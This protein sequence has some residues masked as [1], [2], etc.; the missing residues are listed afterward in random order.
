MLALGF[1]MR[2]NKKHR[3]LHGYIAPKRPQPGRNMANMALTYDIGG[4]R[5]NMAQNCCRTFCMALKVTSA[6]KP[7]VLQRFLA[8]SGPDM[9]PT[10]PQMA[11]DGLNKFILAQHRLNMAS[12]WP[13]LASTLL[14]MVPQDGP[15]RPD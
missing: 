14:Y 12:T 10:C 3:V 7:C 8:L 11:R 6:R 1:Q 15:H 9:A 13:K 5:R 2:C 4:H